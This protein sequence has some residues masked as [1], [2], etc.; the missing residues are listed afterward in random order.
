MAYRCIQMVRVSQKLFMTRSHG[1]LVV[2]FHIWTTSNY[3]FLIVRRFP[4]TSPWL[5]H[6]CDPRKQDTPGLTI[7]LWVITRRECLRGFGGNWIKVRFENF[8]RQNCLDW[9]W[10]LFLSP[11]PHD[12]AFLICRF[13]YFLFSFQFCSLV[14]VLEL[15]QSQ[16][17][18]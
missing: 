5:N 17:T 13:L 16:Q 14:V 3:G 10:T 11:I 18:K 7:A 8:S 12:L 2:D 4:T 1:N 15:S 6:R 9:L